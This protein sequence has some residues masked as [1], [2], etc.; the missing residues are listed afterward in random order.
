[1]TTLIITIPAPAPWFTPNG[2]RHWA[3]TNALVHDWRHAAWAQG[4]IARGEGRA[5]HFTRPVIITATV[6]KT[7]ARLYDPA[8]LLGGAIK[9][10]V[11]GTVDAGLLAG[12]D[13]RYVV[14]TRVR[15]GEPRRPSQLVLVIEEAP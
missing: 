15:A 5:P 9:A 8:N 10:A 1:M 14:E 6:H 3:Q 13:P 7:T 2:R 12:D 11:D 4:R